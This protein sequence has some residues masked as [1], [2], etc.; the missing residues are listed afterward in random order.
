MP[1]EIPSFDMES[2]AQLAAIGANISTCLQARNADMINA[3]SSMAANFLALI[4]AK[5]P[6]QAT[7]RRQRQA[8]SKARN[9]GY[10]LIWGNFHTRPLST[11]WIPG[12]D[13]SAFL[14]G[15]TA[16]LQKLGGCQPC[17]TNFAIYR[18]ST[19]FNYA[20]RESYFESVVN[21]HNH[22]NA[23]KSKN[24]PV[25]ISVTAAMIIWQDWKP[26]AS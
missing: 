8:D 2:F 14:D 19:G 5:Y 12:S 10:R 18:K 6:D 13:D 22:V 9:D 26:A 23:L 25:V 21:F 20:S 3:G 24:N 4:D 15:I 16:Q 17:V 7:A 1:N 11:L